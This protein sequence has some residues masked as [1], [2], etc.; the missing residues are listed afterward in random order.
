MNDDDLPPDYTEPK[1]NLALGAVIFILGL[2]F[3]V[4]AVDFIVGL[5]L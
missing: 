3:T 2:G 4:F 5:F 1:A